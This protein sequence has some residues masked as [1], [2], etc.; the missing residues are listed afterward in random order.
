MKTQTTYKKIKGVDFEIINEIRDYKS[1]NYDSEFSRS[2]VLIECPFCNNEVRAYVWSLCGC[3]KRCLCGAIHTGM[4]E[5][6]KEIKRVR[7]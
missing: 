5:T 2:S 1:Y 3:G 7:K 4:G 6:L